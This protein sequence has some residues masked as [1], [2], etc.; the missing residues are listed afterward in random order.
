MQEA[1][2]ERVLFRYMNDPY[3]K[4]VR[5]VAVFPDDPANPGRLSFISG[6]YD[7]HDKP[8]FD[9]FDEMDLAYYYKHTKPVSRDMHVVPIL[10]ADI[11]AY[12]NTKVNMMERMN[13]RK[14]LI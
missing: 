10:I 8:I 5:W 6:Y 2:M 14:R 1:L 12:C 3:L 11:E 9:P 7:G 13:S 4:V